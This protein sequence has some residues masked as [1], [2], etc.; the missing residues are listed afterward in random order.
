MH[1]FNNGNCG[2]FC[3]DGGAPIG[4]KSFQC[5]STGKKKKQG[6]TNSGRFSNDSCISSQAAKKILLK[7]HQGFSIN[8]GELLSCGMMPSIDSNEQVSEPVTTSA[9]ESPIEQQQSDI[10]ITSFCDINDLN[11]HFKNSNLRFNCGKKSCL[12]LVYSE[13]SRIGSIYH[14]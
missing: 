5:V 8:K 12:G 9:P 7:T 11:S 13:S 10:P 4:I 3:Q 14:R 1:C 6:W 2:V